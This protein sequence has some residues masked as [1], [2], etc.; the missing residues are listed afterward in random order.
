MEEHAEPPADVLKKQ[1]GEAITRYQRLLKQCP[2]FAHANLARLGVG[3]AQY[4]LGNYPEAIAAFVAIPEAD[5]AGE[6]ASA[7]YLLADCL[8]RTFPPEG[9]D[10]VSAARLLEQAEAAAKLLDG[11]V[12][13]ATPPAPAPPA[14]AAPPNP[15]FPD[16]LLKLGYCYQ[17]FG[18]V[19]AD[20]A[21][22]NKLFTQ[23]KEAYE[24][25]MKQFPSDAAVPTAVFERAKCLMLLGDAGTARNELARFRTDPLRSAV[26]APAALVRLSALLRAQNQAPE[27]LKV[28]TECLA[29]R[30]AGL[31]KKPIW[32]DW[33]PAIQH[34]HALAVKESAA[35]DV[36]KLAEARAL[37]EAL[38]KQAAGKPEGANAIWRAGQCRREELMAA[39]AAAK[40]AMA[41]P[42]VKGEEIAAAGA[43]IAEHA[44]NLQTSADALGAQAVELAK[45][46][47]S[48]EPH[49]RLLYEIAWCYRMLA[50]AQIEQARQKLQKEAIDKV[51]AKLAKDAAPDQ[52]PPAL[53]GPEIPLSAIPAQPA[54]KLV[55]EQYQRLTAAGPDSALAVQ[56][57]FELAELLA[58]RA[59]EAADFD[60][61]AALLAD[62]LE[63]NPSPELVDRIKLRL[64]GCLLGKNDPKTALVNVQSVLKNPA[65]PQ[66][67]EARYLAG[68]AY[69]QQ[70]DWPKAI[71]QLAMIRD[72]GPLQNVPEVS[73]RALLRLGYAHAQA[74]QWEPSRQALEILTQRFP[75]SP[76]VEEARYGVGW[77]WQNLKQHDNAVVAYTEV[78]RRTPAELAAK[79]QLQI[80]L[81][82]LEQKRHPEAI[83]ALL[84]TGF[85]YDY[86][87]PCA[88][89]WFEVGRAHMES[90]QPAEA[91]KAWQRV[92]ADYPASS[93][94]K[95]AQEQLGKM[96]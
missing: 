5:R 75:Q 85:T 56:A 31:A 45:K 96:K 37:F 13:P 80:G 36:K 8:I 19:A 11:F 18:A 42:G 70:K 81:C 78:T 50:N 4:R 84:L 93:W 53:R 16:A 7:P 76:W 21:E 9:D 68:E 83:K 26:V 2:D 20:P 61:A 91:A 67:A 44:R 65:A 39:L 63:K 35:G 77:A 15:Q 66:A 82:R 92:V 38:A 43:V 48:S 59:A 95:L 41:K 55:R 12:G 62:A 64:A 24:R 27:A 71:E 34:E 79:A 69:I 14:G 47:V 6:L 29:I 28:M 22:R 10:A 57:R 3:M 17:R 23:A 72:Q 54:E 40:A 33:N 86:P 60:Q 58:Q 51:L 1:L 89:A 74:G 94:A 87:E 46:G 73:D 30:D 49:L 52:A 88:A 90:N 25:L 32:N